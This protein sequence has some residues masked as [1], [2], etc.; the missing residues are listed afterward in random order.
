MM[1]LADLGARSCLLAAHIDRHR[2]ELYLL[3]RALPA[4]DDLL[5]IHASGDP[6]LAGCRARFAP[7]RR[8]TTR[9]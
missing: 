1:T 5:A 9:I 7:M 8:S 6:A 2:K 4:L 3:T